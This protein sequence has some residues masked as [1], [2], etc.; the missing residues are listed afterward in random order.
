MAQ[1]I[2]GLNMSVVGANTPAYYSIALTSGTSGPGS[3]SLTP[4]G[5]QYTYVSFQ[6]GITFQIPG[7]VASGGAVVTTTNG[8]IAGDVFVS[9]AIEVPVQITLYYQ[10]KIVEAYEIAPG[11]TEGN[12]SWKVASTSDVEADPK[13]VLDQIVARPPRG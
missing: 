11:Q 9:P 8:L 5:L 2:Y 7:G 4:G 13:S 10:G 1:A 12:F 3:F 6:G